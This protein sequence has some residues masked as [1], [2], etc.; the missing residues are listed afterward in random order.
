VARPDPG[1]DETRGFLATLRDLDGMIAEHTALDEVAAAGS[2]GSM[3]RD[4]DETVRFLESRMGWRVTDEELAPPL[5]Q[6]PSPARRPLPGADLIPCE[7]AQH[8]DRQG[9]ITRDAA[10]ATSCPPD[11]ALAETAAS[12]CQPGRLKLCRAH[13]VPVCRA[14][15]ARRAGFR[16]PGGDLE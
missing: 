8:G 16:A 13:L 10:S 15:P 4:I 3:R 1:S 6:L 14:T 9:E 7:R 2:P 11:L 12:Q 5:G